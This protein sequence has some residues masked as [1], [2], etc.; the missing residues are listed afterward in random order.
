MPGFQSGRLTRAASAVAVLLL[1]D[2]TA[3]ESAPFRTRNL[4]P[5]I[6]LAAL[7]ACVVVACGPAGPAP[8]S[9]PEFGPESLDDGTPGQLRDAAT[10]AAAAASN[11][12][13]RDGGPADSQRTVASGIVGEAAENFSSS[14]FAAADLERGRI[15]SLACQACHTLGADEDHNLGPN[16]YGMFGRPAAQLDGFEYSA[17]LKASGIVWT[18]ELLEVWLAEPEAFLPGNNMVFAGY[19]SETDRRD[20]LAWLLTATSGLEP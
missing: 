15:L 12:T 10:V 9:V 18:P 1:G 7:V 3:R 19:G 13:V 14:R 5:H 11:A 8:G 2:A 6:W 4:N 17:A 20:L 16:L